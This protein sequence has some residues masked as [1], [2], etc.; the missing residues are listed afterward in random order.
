VDKPIRLLL[1]V[2]QAGQPASKPGEACV[3][4]AGTGALGGISGIFHYRILSMAQED[5]GTYLAGKLQ[6]AVTDM[7]TAT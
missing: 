6:N 4:K 5:L 2:A 1:L 3:G 7:I